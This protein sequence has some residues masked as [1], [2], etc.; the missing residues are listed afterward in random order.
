MNNWSGGNVVFK[1]KIVQYLFCVCVCGGWGALGGV[2]IA[3][4]TTGLRK[5]VNFLLMW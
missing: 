3:C 5:F 4:M 2:S 1:G